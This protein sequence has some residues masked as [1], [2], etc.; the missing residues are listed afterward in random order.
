MIIEN[1][2]QATVGGGGE[3]VGKVFCWQG[4]GGRRGAGVSEVFRFNGL[5]LFL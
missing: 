1:Y 2:N 3:R 4:Q 5:K